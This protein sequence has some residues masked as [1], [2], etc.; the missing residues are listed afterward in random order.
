MGEIVKAISQTP[1]PTIFVIAG[2]V[3]WMLAIA[4]SIAGQITVEPSKRVTAQV[5][6][7]VFIILGLALLFLPPRAESETEKE[8]PASTTGTSSAGPS[9]ASTT[10]S[11]G[12]IF[13]TPV[14]ASS[15]L[16]RARPNREVNCNGTSDEV[17]IC[18]DARLIEL[19][20]QL[21]D[22]YLEKSRGMDQTQQSKLMGDEKLWLR[23]RGLCASNTD[24][25]VNAYNLRISQLK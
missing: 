3:C 12:P 16:A 2:I 5:A 9:T 19:D 10:A 18:N 6:G 20:W 25:L 11:P 21:H 14:P 13:R 17:A 15:N 22:L 23:Q 8:K 24:C 1:L 7:T 4:G